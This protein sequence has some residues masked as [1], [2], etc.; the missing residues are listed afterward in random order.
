[1]VQLHL[2]DQ[3]VIYLIKCGLYYRFYG[4]SI[5]LISGAVWCTNLILRYIWYNILD[6]LIPSLMA[7]S[8][9]LLLRGATVFPYQTNQLWCPISGSGQAFTVARKTAATLPP[10][11]TWE[12]Y[13]KQL[14]RFKYVFNACNSEVILNWVH[15]WH[16]STAIINNLSLILL[17]Y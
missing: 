14:T 8:E 7:L 12:H 1:M 10:G 6:R 11:V 9:L 5:N 17:C 15:S 3:K 4:K 16:R 13:S 2:S